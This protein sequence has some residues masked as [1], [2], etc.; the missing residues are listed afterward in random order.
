M[1]ENHGYVIRQACGSLTSSNRGGLLAHIPDGVLSAP[2]FVVGGLAAVAALTFSLRALDDRQIPRV[3][4]LSA[5]FFAIS[6]FSIPIGPTSIHLLLGGLMGL[7]LGP[8]IFP[9]IFAALLLQAMMFGFGGLTTLGI[10]TVN[11]ALPAALLG[12]A[13]RPAVARAS[14]STAA[15]L[16]TICSVLCVVVTGLLVALSLLFSSSDYAVSAK[17]MIVTYVPLMIIEGLIT[18]SCITFLKKV[19]PELL[20]P[21][22]AGE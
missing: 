8:A 15:I 18:G 2:V 7:I 4:I 14:V 6:L 9:A 19:K 5:S 21:H 13:F 20:N 1:G 22:A 12:L 16:A 11:I 10:N 17:A 3:A